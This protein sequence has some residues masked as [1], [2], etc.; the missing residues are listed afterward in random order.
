MLHVENHLINTLS[1]NCDKIEFN[2]GRDYLNFARLNSISKHSSPKININII[3]NKKINETS[4]SILSETERERK[5]MRTVYFT[6]PMKMRR[7][8]KLLLFLSISWM[9][10]MFYYF[11][12]GNP[13]VSPFFTFFFFRWQKIYR[14][15]IDNEHVFWPWCYF[16]VKYI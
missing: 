9:F 6:M 10:L 8:L 15:L 14:N 1:I 16:D 13:K 2:S 3:I 7:N 4:N 11:Q 5:K 12:S